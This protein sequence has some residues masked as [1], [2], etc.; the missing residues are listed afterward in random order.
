MKSKKMFTVLLGMIM[1]VSTNVMAAPKAINVTINNEAVQFE[2]VKPFVD[3]NNCT[4]VPLRFISEKLGADVK[5]DAKVQQATIS[6]EGKEVILTV[7]K[8][9]MLINGKKASMDTKPVKK[10]GSIFVPVKCIREVLGVET[11]WVKETSTVAISKQAVE[12]VNMTDIVAKVGDEVITVREIEAQVSYEIAVMQLQYQYESSFFKSEEGKKLIADRKKEVVDYII[13]NKVAL[14]KGK[15]LK[16]EPKTS[17]VDTEFKAA[18]ASYPSEAEFKAALSTTGLTEEG[19]KE[20]IKENMTITNIMDKIS[21]EI[22]V[23]DQELKD[24]YNANIVDYMYAPGANMYHI[25]V[26]TEEEANKIKEEY[27]R[28]ASFA[29]LAKKYGTDGTKDEGGA[30]GYIQYE[31][32]AYDQDFLNGAKELKE[33]E[34]S[35]PVKTQFG[36]HLIKVTNVHK[37]IYTTPLEEVK[38]QVKEAVI[39]DK[40]TPAIYEQIEK[41]EA[42]MQIER[43]EDI[44]NRL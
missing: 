43:N 12:P 3:K 9:E 37:D 31:S 29:D 38:D 2:G 39:S 14:I 42:E 25:L 16:L 19:Y 35:A 40:A 10:E 33:G 22:T 5:W 8:A 32:R 27:N 17:E 18:K 44:I 7:G 24:Y 13:K 30:L 21:K 6:Q 20:R 26:A 36:Y 11:K 34:V 28:G 23:S 1:A 15:E 41:W 4:L